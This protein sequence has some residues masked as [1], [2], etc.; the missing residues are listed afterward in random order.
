MDEDNTNPMVVVVKEPSENLNSKQLLPTPATNNQIPKLQKIYNTL[1]TMR[2][3][4]YGIQIRTAIT[5]QEELDEV[6]VIGS[7]PSRWSSSEGQNQR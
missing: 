4:A 7:T 6:I 1:V 5:D 3:R 2:D